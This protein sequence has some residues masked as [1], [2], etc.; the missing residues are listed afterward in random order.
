MTV[1]ILFNMMIIN[2]DYPIY[3]CYYYKYDKIKAISILLYSKIY[4][5]AYKVGDATGINR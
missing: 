1:Y 3:A 2:N 4:S 5:N